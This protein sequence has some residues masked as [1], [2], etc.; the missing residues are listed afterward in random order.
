MPVWKGIVGKGFTAA[1]FEEY[2]A[3]LTFSAWRP[4]FV[5]LHNTAAPTFAQWHSTPGAQRMLNLQTY[6]RDSLKWTGGPHLFVADDL[7]WAFTPLTAP[8][9]HSPSWNNAAWGV[10]MVGDFATE[11][12]PAGVHANTIAALATLHG[13]LGLDP[14]KLRLHREDPLTTHICPGNKV[15][16]AEVIAEVTAALAKQFAGEHPDMTAVGDVGAADA[17][18]S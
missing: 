6:Y 7:I 8:G 9:V 11:S 17:H 10:E 14:A 13:A 15:S 5:V 16:K 12:I 3:G 1:Q 18:S 4:T 2:V